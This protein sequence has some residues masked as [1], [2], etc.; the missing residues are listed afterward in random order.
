MVAIGHGHRLVDCEDS[1]TSPTVTATPCG[2]RMGH[3]F[4]SA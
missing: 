2:S 1:D 4:W 3:L